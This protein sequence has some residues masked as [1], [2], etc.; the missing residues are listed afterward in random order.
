VPG[1]LGALTAKGY[2]GFVAVETFW[3]ESARL[4]PEAA[5]AATAKAFAD[6]LARSQVGEA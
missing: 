6:V 3:E 5:A 2:E 4:G 1:L